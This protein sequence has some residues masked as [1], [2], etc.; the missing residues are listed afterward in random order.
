MQIGKEGIKYL[1]INSS[2]ILI[3]SE[4]TLLNYLKRNKAEEMDHVLAHK[5]VK[6]AAAATENY[7]PLDVGILFKFLV[8]SVKQATMSE[9]SNNITN[10][11]DMIIKRLI[12]NGKK[13]A[14]RNGLADR[15]SFNCKTSKENQS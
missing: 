3:D 2:V 14:S 13:I 4:Q 10:E 6:I 8:Q 11:W 9:N 12:E 1:N 7:Q 5:I 15:V